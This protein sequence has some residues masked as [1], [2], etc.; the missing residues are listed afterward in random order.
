MFPGAFQDE[1]EDWSEDE[2]EDW[3]EDWSEDLEDLEDDQDPLEYLEEDDKDSLEDEEEDPL[4]PQ[5]EMVT[6]S[7]SVY[8][9]LDSFEELLLWWRLPGH[10]TP[11]QTPKTSSKD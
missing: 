9:Y 6:V 4:L 10:F 2:S 7:S 11:P 8:M 1:S 5:H 3:S